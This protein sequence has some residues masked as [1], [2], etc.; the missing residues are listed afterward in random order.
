MNFTPKFCVVPIICGILIIAPDGR[1][2]ANKSIDPATVAVQNISATSK[3]LRTSGNISIIPAVERIPLAGDHVVTTNDFSTVAWYKNKHW[4]KKNAPIIGGAAGGGL[5]GGLAG[6]GTGAVI[7]GAVGAGGGY[8]Y[9]HHK[10]HHQHHDTQY[11]TTNPT[12][13]HYEHSAPTRVRQ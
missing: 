7:G 8:L 1:N 4:W 6:G 2:K 13:N 3:I 12:P 10:E 9:K 11:R 5:I